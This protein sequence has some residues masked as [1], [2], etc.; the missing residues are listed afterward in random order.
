MSRVPLENIF[1]APPE[2]ATQRL[3]LRRLMYSDIK[4]FYHYA[5]NE[6]VA[7]HVLW[8]AHRSLTD[9]FFTIQGHRFAYRHRLP[10]SWA[11]VLQETG[12]LIGTIG[13]SDY[14]PEH[15]RGELGYSLAEEQWGKG[16][17]TEALTALTDFLWNE[18]DVLRLQAIVEADNPASIRVLE[19]SGF[20]A[21]GTMQSYVINK[22]KPSDVILFGMTRRQWEALTSPESP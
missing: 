13:F 22:G 4:A 18:T 14:S 2:I 3:L 10:C 6:K 7:Q 15:K 5:S 16:F 1:H 21:E 20:Q 19:K 17:A 12:D 8:E 11:L 9:T